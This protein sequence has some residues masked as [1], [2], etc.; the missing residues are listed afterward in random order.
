VSATALRSDEAFARLRS[1]SAALGADPLQVQA[2]GGNTSLKAGGVMLIKA[3]GAWLA[4][5]LAQDVF[6][7]VDLGR[8]RR[9]MAEDAPEAETAAGCA[10]EGDGALRPSI[11][12]TVHAAL[13]A[14]VV[15]HT[16]CVATI[17]L[18][19]R[20]DGEAETARK[21]ADLGA[22]WIPYAKPGLALSREIATRAGP[23]A[24]LLVLGNHGLVAAGD[25]PEEAAA[26][27]AAVA[28][29][30]AG[31]VR[32][33]AEPAPRL[34]E[35]LAGSGYAPARAASVHALA[36]DPE[37]AAL[38]AAGPW[39]PDQVVFLGPAVAVAAEREAARAAAARHAARFGAP[40]ALML[41][42]GRGAAIAES[43]T[44]S[45][46][47]LAGALGDV[48]ARVGPGSAPTPIPPDEVAALLDWDAE[49]HRQSLAGARG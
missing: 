25:T 6:A 8:L 16:H 46:H 20:A 5:A 2:A 11:E 31:P 19:I 18:A 4:D 14:P 17:A 39:F 22:V 3:S 45:A 41:L 40:P 23:A 37:L 30:L 15:I 13:D 10:L 33:G 29:R 28:T 7:A 49:K 32:D 9:L 38:A 47:A 34:A 42:P 43:A 35:T 1:V 27:V 48:L 12:T 21:L 44:P 36:R 24:R 26:L